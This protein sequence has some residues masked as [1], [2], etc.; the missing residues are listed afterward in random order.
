MNEEMEQ[1]RFETIN[2][3]VDGAS[4]EDERDEIFVDIDI[5]LKGKTAKFKAKVDTGAQGNIIPLRIYKQMYPENINEQGT[6]NKEALTQT[7]TKITAYNKTRIHQFGTCAFPC[8]YSDVQTT[9][10]FYVSDVDGPAILGLQSCRKLKLVQMNCNIDLS[11]NT[12][13]DNKEDLKRLFPD[14]FDGIGDFEGEYHIVI[15]P[16]VPPVIHAARRCPLPIKNDIKKELDEMVKM[17]VIT[18]VTEPTDWVS[19]LAY[20]QKPNGRWRICLDPKDLN[21]AIKRTHHHT[22]TLDEITHQFAG[23]TVFSKLDAR[24]GYWSIKL[25]EE[26]SLLTTFNS[27]GF[28]RFRFKRLP[29]GLCVSQDIFQHRM[30]QILE[31]CPGTLGIADDV[32]VYGTTEEEHDKNLLQLMNVARESGL[33]FNMDKCEIKKQSISFFGLIYDANGVTPN[34]QRIEAIEAIEP[35][36]TAKA[37]Q[38]FLGIATYMSSFVPRLSELTAPLRELIKKEV[39]Y[40]W[41]AS[42]QTSFEN[43]KSMIIREVTLSYYDVN[44][45]TVIEVDASLKGVGAALVQDG[46]VIAFGSKAFTETEQRYANIEREMLAVVHACEQ[47]HMYIYGKTFVVESDHKPLEMIHLKNLMSAPP[48]LQRM[49]LRLQGYDVTIRYKPGKMMLLSDGLSRLNPLPKGPIEKKT[50]QINFVQFSSTRVD[51]LKEATSSDPELAALRDIIVDGWPERRQSVPKPLQPYWPFRDELSI[52]DGLVLKGDRIV[53]PQAQQKKILETIHEGHQGTTK[54]QLRAKS[55]V[56]WL[57]VNRDIEDLVKCCPVCQEFSKSR[58]PE[59]LMQHEIP[60]RPWQVIGTDL[61]YIDGED[62]IL[63]ADY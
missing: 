33:V 50:V 34:P 24:H 36:K 61:F 58:S 4:L 42:H 45:P 37:L 60:T 22:P 41:T 31:K 59:P 53:I 5:K 8:K 35:P 39:P 15:D 48:R 40:D 47:F 23:S 52:E 12:K 10:D 11:E 9:L 62:Y 20:S 43:I 3:N 38:E 44:K 51:I 18:P 16:N 57:N 46:R 25:D 56:Y 7:K 63:I 32:A 29:F 19:S 21:K 28:G 1:L 17:D 55:A 27:P 26:S 14:R 49:L 30:D 13:V 6:P 54:C 2:I